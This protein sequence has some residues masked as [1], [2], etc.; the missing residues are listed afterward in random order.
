MTLELRKLLTCSEET[1]PRA[2]DADGRPMRKAAALAVIANP[3][4]GRPYSA[5]L[6]EITDHGAE[7]GEL[8]GRTAAEVLGVAVESYGKAALVGLSGEQEHAVACTIGAF[9][10]AIRDAIGGGAT[11]WISSVTKRCSPG[12]TIDVPLASIEDIWVRSHYDAY[13]VAAPDAPLPDEIVVILAVASRGR[14]DARVGGRTLD[15]ARRG[16]R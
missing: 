16:A 15:E 13:T 8:L 2:G 11:Q 6:D 12:T 9:G 1:A 5:E 4:A 10:T 7:L 14:L 3:Y